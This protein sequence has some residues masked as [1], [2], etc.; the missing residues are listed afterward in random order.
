MFIYFPLWVFRK[1][2]H[3]TAFALNDLLDLRKQLR[4]ATAD[5]EGRGPCFP[6][7]V[8]KAALYG[9]KLQKLR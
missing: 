4:L 1:D 6:L 9:Q 5:E 3:E 8:E 7:L 2:G